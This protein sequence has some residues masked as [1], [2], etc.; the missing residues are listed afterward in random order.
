M[1]IKALNGVNSRPTLEQA[2]AFV[3]VGCYKE[4]KDENRIAFDVRGA[5]FGIMREY[6]IL[7]NKYGNKELNADGKDLP[8]AEA[9]FPDAEDNKAQQDYDE[10]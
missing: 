2:Q 8:D 10:D 3:D 9:E 4:N 7:L 1:A 6:D 5:A